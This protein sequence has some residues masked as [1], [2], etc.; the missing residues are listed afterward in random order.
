MKRKYTILSILSV[1][2]LIAG[3]MIPASADS[4]EGSNDGD[5]LFLDI[6]GD[7]G[8]ANMRIDEKITTIQG[9][10]KYYENGNFK[11]K[12]IQDKVI[13]FGKFLSDESLRISIIDMN[14]RKKII[15][16]I[17]K[18]STQYIT[19]VKEEHVGMGDI[20]AAE[21]QLRLEEEKKKQEEEANKV[22][23][24]RSEYI[25][26]DKEIAILIQSMDRVS[27]YSFFDFDVRLV[28]PHIN[29]LYNYYES[30]GYINDVQIN[31]TVKD[32]E[33]KILNTFSGNTT[34]N[35][36]Y[37]P[38]STTYFADNTNTRDAFTLEILATKYFDDTATFV[39]TTLLKEFFVFIPSNS[40][41]GCPGDYIYSNGRCDPPLV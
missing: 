35:G 34:M 5:Y 36:H 7:K 24:P 31:A 6:D 19:P 39:T 30:K 4:F 23:I 26:S 21:E 33:G 22:V 14:E 38:D 27:I 40:S 29:K 32:G 41:K 18:L 17:Q 10:I 9:E 3:L 16:D 15:L 8:I 1:A 2:S 37:S 25:Q 12:A 13:L 28:D 20:R 11:I